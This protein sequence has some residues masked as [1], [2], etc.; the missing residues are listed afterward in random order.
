[1]PEEELRLP[2]FQFYNLSWERTMNAYTAGIVFRA[3]VQKQK[4]CNETSFRQLG[5]GKFYFYDCN[6]SQILT[7]SLK[8]LFS[9]NDSMG[10]MCFR[11]LET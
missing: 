10:I 1:M 8:L 7:F 3:T 11:F 6:K 9:S 2:D 5:S 4:N